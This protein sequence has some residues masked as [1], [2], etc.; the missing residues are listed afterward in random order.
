MTLSVEHFHATSHVKTPLMSQLQYSRLFMTTVK[1]SLK[2][3]SHWSAYYFTSEKGNWYPPSENSL[4]YSDLTFPKK[5]INSPINKEAEELLIE[6]ASNYTR[7]ERQ[8]TVRQETTMSKMGTLPFYLYKKDICKEAFERGIYTDPQSSNSSNE[9][10]IDNYSDNC[11]ENED[12]EEEYDTDSE[13]EYITENS[14]DDTAFFIIGR[15]TRY[16]RQI[17]VNNRIFT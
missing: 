12:I 4:P 13:E 3:N 14:I 7:A 15:S 8:R 17:K 10:E 11:V 16:G 6:W 1:E 5:F 9:N 2:R